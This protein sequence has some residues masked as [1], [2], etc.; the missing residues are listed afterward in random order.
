MLLAYSLYVKGAVDMSGHER[1]RMKEVS[2]P[3]GRLRY[4]DEGEGPVIVLIHGLL[5]SASLWSKVV[6]LLAK[7]FRVVVPDL[8][9]GCHRV[10]MNPDA[11][12]SPPG[13]AAL[14]ADMLDALDLD[15]V[16]LVGNDTG[17]ALSQIAAATRPERIGRL[18]L[19]NC[20]VLEHFPPKAFKALLGAAKLPGVLTGLMVPA[21]VIRPLR[22]TNLAFGLLMK[23]PDHDLMDEWVRAFFADSGVRRDVVKVAKGIDPRQTIDAAERLAA[24]GIPLLC[25]WA[26]EDRAFK[27][28]F[29]ERLAAMVPGA[30]IERVEDSFTFVMVDQPERTAELIGTFARERQ[31][32]S[33]G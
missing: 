24:A 3:Q 23:R 8:P 33:S 10:P 30:R 18:V 19:T 16:T 14:I 17:G 13:V 7:D 31:P 11:D 29:A 22:G 9:L 28:E 5:V 26:P 1:L 4:A 20:D 32:A 6:P 2:L 21:R 25:V 12:L 27:I 15:D